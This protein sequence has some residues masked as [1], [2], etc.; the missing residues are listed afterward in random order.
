MKRA[1]VFILIPF[2]LGIVFSYKIEVKLNILVVLMVIVIFLF[3]IA[4][5]IKKGFDITLFFVVFVIGIISYVVSIDSS[6]DNFYDKDLVFECEIVDVINTKED[7]S[8]YKA[9]IRKIND[10][11]RI[12]SVDEDLLLRVYD[13]QALSVGD[14]I[15]VN[16]S[17]E[18]PNLN[19]NPGLFNYKLYLQSQGIFYTMDANEHFIQIL[20]RNNL[21]FTKRISNTFKDYVIE[22]LDNS[23]SRKSSKIM[24]SIILGDDKFLDNHTQNKFRTLGIAHILAVSGLHIG[25]IF[26]F[27]SL[28]LKKLKINRKISTVFAVFFIW[29]YAYFIGFPASVLRASVMVSILALSTITYRRYDPLNSLAFAAL[30]LLIYRPSFLFSMGF[31]FSFI[32]TFSLIVFSIRL[33]ILLF[34]RDS[35]LANTTSSLIAVQMGMIPIT[36]YYFNNYY[37]LSII[38]NFVVVP[39]LSLSLS[40]SFIVLIIATFSIKIASVLG[41]VIDTLI[42]FSDYFTEIFYNIPVFNITLRSMTFSDIVIYYLII[43]IILRFIKFSSVQFNVLKSLFIYFSIV[44]LIHMAFI[45]TDEKLIINFIDVGQGDCSLIRSKDKNILV[46]CGGTILSDF[47]IGANTVLPYLRKQGIKKLNAVFI[48]H[49]HEDHCE[50]LLSLM[51]NININNI[52][53]GYIPVDNELYDSIEF[54]ANKYSIPITILSKDDTIELNKN[55]S[56]K[57]ISQANNADNLNKNNENNLSLVLLLEAYNKKVLFTGD[58]EKDAE[59]NLI[60][61]NYIND[62]DVIKVPHHGSKTSSTL[63]LIK[64]FEPEFAIIQVGKNSFG[65][66]SQEVIER[67][68]NNNV[69]VYRNDLSGMITV[70]LEQELV[71]IIPYIQEK[72]TL[73]DIIIRYNKEILYTLILLLIGYFIITKNKA[74]YRFQ[75]I[76]EDNTYL[77]WG[78]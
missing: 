17:L 71:K 10:N 26:A 42:N 60:R 32:A 58:I 75:S 6:L 31:Q 12:Y 15:N 27:I 78:D 1:F 25:L 24:K 19:T 3:T 11:K 2:I 41:I 51:G 54:M 38:S 74:Y 73:H 56:I 16:G 29:L 69:K 34:N 53:I 43:F 44:I 36:A 20:S 49:F 5:I 37:L 9:N 35:K 50:G 22:T 57:V 33:R 52:F 59:N 46:D 45:M 55:I 30:I 66:P 77:Q 61:E 7:Y 39:I 23:L 21:T 14:I 48:S 4:I 8:S 47:D 40:L 72:M 67:Y 65:H 62:I 18:K 28:I 68:Q 63:S 70:K 64:H 13:G 76:L